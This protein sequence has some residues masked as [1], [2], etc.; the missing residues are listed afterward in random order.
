MHVSS[1]EE[2]DDYEW[3]WTGT[4]GAWAMDHPDDPDAADA[5]EL[6]RTHHKAWLHGYRGVLGFVCL[7]LTE[8]PQPE[9]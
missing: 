9:E 7:V 6:A 4:L 3:S 2:W 5:V 1:S 8:T